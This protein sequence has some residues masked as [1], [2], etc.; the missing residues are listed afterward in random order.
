MAVVALSS[1]S[2]VYHFEAHGP[3]PLKLPEGPLKGV[4][5]GSSR[6]ARWMKAGMGGSQGFS[7]EVNPMEGR[8]V[9]APGLGVVRRELSCDPVLCAIATPGVAGHG[10][11]DGGAGQGSGVLAGHLA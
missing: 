3:T 9:G 7:E 11:G 1:E 8:R 4:C 6:K 2:D 10:G 5:S